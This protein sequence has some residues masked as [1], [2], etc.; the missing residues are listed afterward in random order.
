M[1]KHSQ[2]RSTRPKRT[3]LVEQLEARRVLATF[4]V[5]STADSGAGSLRDA[6]ER[7]N[8]SEGFDNITFDAALAGQAISLSSGEIVITDELLIDGSSLDSGATIDLSA[9]DATPAEDN[10]DGIRAFRTTLEEF[11]QRLE[12]V[13]LSIIGGDVDGRGGAILGAS[14]ISDSFFGDNAASEGGAFATLSN[15][16][17][18]M[19]T[20]IRDSEFNSNTA[21]G[22]GGALHINGYYNGADLINVTLSNNQA[23][24]TGGAIS[25]NGM[26]SISIEDSTIMDNTSTGDGGGVYANT[27]NYRPLRIG[28]SLITGNQ[29]GGEG[30]GIATAGTFSGTFEDLT[31]RNNSATS[32]GGG[33]S[34]D[35]NN[36]GFTVHE[37][38]ISSNS[39]GAIGGGLYVRLYD[40]GGSVTR[41]TIADNLATEHGGGIGHHRHHWTRP[42]TGSIGRNRLNRQRKPS[43]RKR[44]W[45]KRCRYA[46]KLHSL[47]QL[48]HRY[49]RRRQNGRRVGHL[50]DHCE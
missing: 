33:L 21:S 20:V 11:D 7:A 9:G 30:G 36:D 18:D 42:S 43:W 34:I 39:S 3:L 15:L 29:A 40:A 41:S 17:T 8:V 23:G 2:R 12:F 32:N 47:G 49:R 16:Q 50:L 22:A 37:S 25:S 46:A 45:N 4:V 26:T 19:R 44:R 28:S 35:N 10:G 14:L 13:G 24:A 31:I 48:G 27:F 5:S 6:V 1:F 38:V